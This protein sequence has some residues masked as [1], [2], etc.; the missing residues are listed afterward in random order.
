MSFDIDIVTIFPAFFKGPLE[1]SLIKK[2]REKRLIDVRVHDLRKYTRDKHKTVDDKPFG[3][4]PGMVMKPD[5]IFECVEDI[6]SKHPGGRVIMLDARGERLTQKKAQQLSQHS[7]LILLCGHYEGID[8]RVHE[9]LADELISIGDFVT[10]GGEAPS[11]SLIEAV[12]R[13]VPGVIG[14][15]ESLKEESFL[16]DVENGLE[17]PQ[18]TRPRDFRG[19]KVP[20]VLV[21]GNHKE[22][23]KWRA[24]VSKEVTKKRRPDLQK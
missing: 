8:H 13:L 2:A 19:W 23:A 3:G 10:M 9:H 20:D 16:Q 14:N 5:P 7:H 18:Y 24:K 6:K 4:G 17:Y 22:V 11:L 15:Q 21:S 12:V 1:E